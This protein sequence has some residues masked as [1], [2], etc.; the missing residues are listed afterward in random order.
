M[1]RF[2]LAKNT[3]IRMDDKIA[4]YLIL[5]SYFVKY[6]HFHELRFTE[7]N[8]MVISEKHRCK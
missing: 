2:S 4:T 3:D 8:P 6:N 1:I 7:Q 5:T